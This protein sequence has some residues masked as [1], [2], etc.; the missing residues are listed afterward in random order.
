MNNNHLTAMLNLINVASQRGTFRGEELVDVG[1]LFNAIKAEV[2]STANQPTA[3][4]EIESVS[5]DVLD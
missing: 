4:P 5:G 3:E 1:T 2:E